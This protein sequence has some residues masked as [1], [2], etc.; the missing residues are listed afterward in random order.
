[1]VHFKKTA[2]RKLTFILTLII[3]ATFTACE[4][5]KSK[6][7]FE[8][9]N[10]DLETVDFI[11][12]KNRVAKFDTLDNQTKRLTDKQK[13]QFVVKFNNSKSNGLRKAFPLYF[14]DVYLKGGTKRSF[15]INGQYIKEKNDYCYDFGDSK[16]IEMIW[17]ELN[18]DHSKNIRYVFED[19]IQ[20]Q[21]STDSQDDKD[22]MTKSLKSIASVTD[23]DDLDLLINVWMYYDPT[24]YP[25]IPEIYRILKAS[26]PHSIEAVKNR[27]DNKKEWETDNTAPYSDLK[28]LLKR[29]ENE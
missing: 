26:R 25:D 28:N 4:L 6:S 10:I 11:E 29:L 19:Y 27:I 5:T 1:M 17:N 8:K 13:N 15:R 24:D 18:V 22:L 12:I 16:F 3:S 9:I 2:V 23:K 7:N 14:I 21:E 20:Y